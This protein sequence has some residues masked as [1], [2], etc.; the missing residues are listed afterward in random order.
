MQASGGVAQNQELCG[1]RESPNR[2]AGVERETG[3]IQSR[4]GFCFKLFL[5]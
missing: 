3:N 4:D 5:F 1:A 2:T